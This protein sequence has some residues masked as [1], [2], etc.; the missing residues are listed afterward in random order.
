MSEVFGVYC[1]AMYSLIRGKVVL[2]Y[3]PL[4]C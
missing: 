4:T 1:Y 3:L 2:E